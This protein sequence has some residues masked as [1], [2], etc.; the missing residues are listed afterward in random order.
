[1][2]EVQ[3]RFVWGVRRC[4]SGWSRAHPFSIEGSLVVLYKGVRIIGMKNLER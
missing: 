2:R 1:M 4:S 3:D